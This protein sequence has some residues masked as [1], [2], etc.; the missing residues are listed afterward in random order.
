MSAL[1]GN[2]DDTWVES[3]V[4]IE[5]EHCDSN[6]RV[7]WEHDQVAEEAPVFCPFCSN[8]LSDE[9]F[10]S[11]DYIDSENESDSAKE[12]INDD[13]EEIEPGC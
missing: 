10:V 9:S 3:G 7:H 11:N 1:D 4:Q 13:G 6:F 5:C 12:I 8:R 2:P